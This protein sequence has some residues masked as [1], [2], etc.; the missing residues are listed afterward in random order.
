[1]GNC[2]DGASTRITAPKTSKRKRV[3][4]GKNAAPEW[5]TSFAEKHEKQQ[6]EWRTELREFM[7]RQEQIQNQR[8]A[9]CHEIVSIIKN[10]TG[11]RER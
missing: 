1:M 7:Q 9:V 5:F 3:T 2:G 4:S 10:I 6:E 8:L 11:C